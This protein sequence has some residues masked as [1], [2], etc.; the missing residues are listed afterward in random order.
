[1]IDP[2]PMPEGM[3]WNMLNMMSVSEGEWRVCGDFE[4]TRCH[5]PAYLHPYTNEI[6]GCLN[7]GFTTA[8]VSTHFR[9]L[10]IS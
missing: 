4:C 1:M 6:W 8:S 10:Q 3:N 9:E 2:I 7:C 5:G